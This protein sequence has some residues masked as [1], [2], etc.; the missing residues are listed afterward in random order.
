MDLAPDG[1]GGEKFNADK[2]DDNGRATN[3]FTFPRDMELPPKEEL[4]GDSIGRRSHRGGAVAPI[5]LPAAGMPGGPGS[6]SPTGMPPTGM[7]SGSTAASL[8]PVPAALPS[9]DHDWFR[10]QAGSPADH[11]LMR[12]LLLELPP[13]TG[14]LDPKWLD[15][16]LEAARATLGLI[17][18][19]VDRPGTPR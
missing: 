5:E 9:P 2:L 18:A 10:Q 15:Q 19:R 11:P 14:A 17:Y 6:G 4:A 13:R 8:P 12:G 1:F 16:W 7:P 3:G